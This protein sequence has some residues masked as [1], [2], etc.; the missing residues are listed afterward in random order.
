MPTI[1][2]WSHLYTQH[3]LCSQT[4]GEVLDS[5]LLF[6]VAQAERRWAG[7]GIFTCVICELTQGQ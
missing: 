2:S 7:M 4:P 3:W 6:G 1:Y 5:P